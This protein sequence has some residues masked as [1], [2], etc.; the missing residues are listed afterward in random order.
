[1]AFVDLRRT[2]TAGRASYAKCGNLVK[3]S[4]QTALTDF[5]RR[6]ALAFGI[7][8]T[9]SDGRAHFAELG[10]AAGVSITASDSTIH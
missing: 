8:R 10:G 3:L 9:D 5:G 6:L 7:L 4:P 1:V 2:L